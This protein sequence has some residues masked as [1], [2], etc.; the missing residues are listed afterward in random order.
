MSLTVNTNIPSLNAQRSLNQTTRSLNRA[1]ERLSSGLRINHSA[2]DAAGL[3]IAN[4]LATQVKGMTQAIRNAGDGMSLIGTVDGAVGQQIDILQRIREL[5][6]QAANDINSS[7]NRTTIQQEITAQLAELTRIAN[8]TEFNGQAL[9]TG[10][11]LQKNLQVGANSGQTIAISLSDLRATALG[12]IASTTG[13]TAI[14]TTVAINGTGN[15]IINGTTIANSANYITDDNLSTANKSGGAIAKAA[16]INASKAATGVTATVQEAT[17]T[18]GAITA[19][20]TT[21]GA[22]FSI[23]GVTIYDFAADGAVATLAADSDGLIR[24]LINAKSTQTGVVATMSGAFIKLTAADGRNVVATAGGNWALRTGI[25]TSTYT[26]AI[27]LTSSSTVTWTAAAAN[28]IG[29]AVAGTQTVNNATAINSITVD[30]QANAADALIRL[31]AALS[32]LGNSQSQLGAISNRLQNTIN[33]LEVSVENMSASESR[34]RD[35]DFAT[36]TANMTRAQII[37]QA[38]V[39]VLSQAN[40][41]P[42]A[43]LTLL[44]AR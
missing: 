34:I 31:D 22:T 21:A 37:Q 26:G 41:S 12:A 4:G 13:T 24:S 29:L 8:T 33:N 42:Q 39:A 5:T 43:A 16:A 23:N 2:D 9:M 1:M 30:T 27:K 6:V 18:A 35:A 20:N 28:V 7:S 10:S 19:G 25:A 14:D 44:S 17:Y 40:L 36:E 11:F 15:V 32:S 38:G 3:A